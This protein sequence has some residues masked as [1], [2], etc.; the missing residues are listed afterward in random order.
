MRRPLAIGFAWGAFCAIGNGV[1]AASTLVQMAV[2]WVWVAGL[3]GSLSGANSAVRAAAVGAVTLVAANLAYFGVGML[4]RALTGEAP[5]GGVGFLAL[6][7]T[8]GLIIGPLAGVVGHRL[9]AQRTALTAVVALATVSIAEP[10]ALWFHIDRFDAR[11]VY[12]TVAAAG[13][14]FPLIWFRNAWRQAASAT[15]V[16]MGLTYPTAVFLEAAL[17]SLGQVSSPMRL[18]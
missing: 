5:L 3:A 2:P 10:L 18:I 1:P 13:L 14:V 8:I 6:W 12:L 4:A 11:A 9:T 15:A 16:A 17:I 7:A